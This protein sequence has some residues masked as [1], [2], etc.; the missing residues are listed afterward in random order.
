M[1][2]ILLRMK[3]DGAPRRAR[4]RR[5][6]GGLEAE[7]LATLWAADRSLTPAAVQD[8]LGGDLAYTTVMTTLTRLLE[9]G[10][11]SRER[12]G[13]AYSYTAVLDEPGI[14]AARMRE[15]LEDGDREVVLAR[16]V[17]SLSDEEE[18]VLSELLRGVRGEGD[19]LA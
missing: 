17:G 4:G 12:M 19:Q 8:E 15:L 13:R 6:A 1:P 10:V 2:G 18:R 7:V 11:V 9:K 3:D 14:A 16:F 5:P